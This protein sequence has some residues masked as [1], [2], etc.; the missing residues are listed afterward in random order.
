MRGRAT[1]TF[2]EKSLLRDVFSL[3]PTPRATDGTHGAPNQRGSSGDL[4]LPSAVAQLSPIATGEST[5]PPL[6]DG[7]LF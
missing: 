7:G 3:L 1:A 5:D 4:M 2:Q 6:N